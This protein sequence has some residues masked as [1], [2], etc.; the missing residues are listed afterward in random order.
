MNKDQL[1]YELRSLIRE[2]EDL[3]PSQTGMAQQGL[4]Y[5]ER[6]ETTRQSLGIDKR[7]EALRLCLKLVDEHFEE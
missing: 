6:I 7:L 4:S 5:A 2:A 1:E 3:E